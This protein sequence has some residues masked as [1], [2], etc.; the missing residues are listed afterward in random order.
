MLRLPFRR[1]SYC[2]VLLCRDN[3]VGASATSPIANP[4]TGEYVGQ[5]LFDFSVVGLRGALARSREPEV[6]LIVPGSTNQADTV[7]YIPPNRSELEWEERSILHYLFPNEPSASFEEDILPKMKGC[8]SSDLV[9]LVRTAN[10]I[11]EKI[12]LAY[13]YVNATDF[14]PVDPS[15][16]GRGVDMSMQSV[17]VVGVVTYDEKLRS[18][19]QKVE[20]DIYDHVERLGIIYMCLVLAL[21]FMYA[22]FTCMVR[23]TVPLL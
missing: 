8:N 4:N 1:A 9:E 17:Y 11:S 12:W 16:F 15:D 6:F 19:F 3:Q 14:R 10:G 18:P 5:T 7:I 13:H 23:T 21:T 20:D 2:A 22:F